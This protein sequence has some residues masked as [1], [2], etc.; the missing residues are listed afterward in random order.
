M[1][2]P[3]YG[4]IGWPV[5]HSLSPSMQIAAF[6]AIGIDASYDLISIE[7]KDLPKR[8]SELKKTGYNG[9]NVTIPH[10]Q[11]VL[12][13]LD[14]LETTAKF[15]GSVNTVVS[16]E[17]K[18]MG[19]STDGY[20]LEMAVKEAFGLKIRDSS[21]LFWGTGGAAIAASV[22]FAS[23]GARE[24]YLVNRTGDKADALKSKLELI[25]DNVRTQ[26]ISPAAIG[27]LKSVFQNVDVVVQST[28]LGL[29]QSDPISIPHELLYP[30]TKIVDMVYFNTRLL[31]RARDMG[32]HAVDGR[33]MLLYQGARS[34]FLWTGIEA[35]IDVMRE[36]LNKAL[37]RH[38]HRA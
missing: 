22:H 21:F 29:N 2:K 26:V 28:S 8:I 12:C 16:K 35:P 7:P 11:A 32:C 37:A 18:L 33:S 13:C 31:E 23:I 27:R 17:G 38:P 9:W 10:K 34:F 3:R 1:T 36:A 24:I 6:N 25:A 19:Y 5:T 14:E 20:G 30:S 4:I 15:A